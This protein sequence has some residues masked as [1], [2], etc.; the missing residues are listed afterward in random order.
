MYIKYNRQEKFLLNYSLST[1]NQLGYSGYIDFFQ[2][3][4]GLNECFSYHYAVSDIS[5][6][7]LHSIQY[8]FGHAAT[9]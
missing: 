1:N 4:K 8:Y 2:Y 7:R 5:A 6:G 9:I 3:L